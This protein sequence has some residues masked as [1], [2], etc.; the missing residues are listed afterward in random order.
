MDRWEV[1]TQ[2]VAVKRANNCAGF[3]RCYGAEGSKLAS[4]Q[5]VRSRA[6]H[7]PH[8]EVKLKE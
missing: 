8:D 1:F 5:G 7:S 4:P 2:F 6:L 3:W